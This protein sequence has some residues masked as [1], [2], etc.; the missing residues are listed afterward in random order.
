MFGMQPHLSTRLPAFVLAASQPLQRATARGCWW[1]R[2]RQWQPAT[3]TTPKMIQRFSANTF[4]L[5]CVVLLLDPA[6]TYKLLEVVAN[7]DSS[8][9]V[10]V[11]RRRG[12]HNLGVLP[13]IHS[14]HARARVRPHDVCKHA[15]AHKR[16]YT[17]T[18]ALTHTHA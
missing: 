17:H 6:L 18:C 16:K 2:R 3:D 10:Q 7:I 1:R 12:V 5:A 11:H 8:G 15:I 4:F 14:T 13:S 9:G